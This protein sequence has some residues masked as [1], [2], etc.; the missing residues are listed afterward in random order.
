MK[1]RKLLLEDEYEKF[2]EFIDVAKRYFK[3]MSASQIVDEL[4]E[5]VLRANHIDKLYN[6]TLKIKESEKYAVMR[7]NKMVEDL[8]DI[9]SRMRVDDLENELGAT[10]LF[11]FN[12]LHKVYFNAEMF[13]VNHRRYIVFYNGYTKCNSK[14]LIEKVKESAEKVA[15][16]ECNYEYNGH[17]IKEYFEFTKER[18]YNNK[19]IN[20]IKDDL[21]GE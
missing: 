4:I 2:V 20:S 13:E 18:E 8:R 17:V 12:G 10:I 14:Q 3:G 1:K 5:C 6:D 16:P 9:H 19:D 15:I 7:R 21:K 11:K